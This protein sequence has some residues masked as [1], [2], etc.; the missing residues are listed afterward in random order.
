MTVSQVQRLFVRRFG[1]RIGDQTAQ[2]VLDHMAQNA[3]SS[4]LPVMGGDA[5]TGAAIRAEIPLQL[6]LQSETPLAGA[7]SS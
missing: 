4:H 5:R 1:I 7:A 3:E 2:Y 6:L